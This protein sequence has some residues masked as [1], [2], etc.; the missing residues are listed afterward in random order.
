[1][2]TERR[3]QA[4]AEASRQAPH[5][6]EGYTTSEARQMFTLGVQW[7]DAQP[8]AE[9]AEP[10]DAEVEALAVGMWKHSGE[11]L[12]WDE[13]AETWLHLARMGL[14]EMRATS[15]PTPNTADTPDAEEAP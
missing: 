10:S 14:R 6:P 11:G 5:D 7:A 15:V 1:M 13:V 4:Q 8:V 3:D 2:K 12:R 9:S